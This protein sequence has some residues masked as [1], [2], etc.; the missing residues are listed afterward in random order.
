[1]LPDLL[2]AARAVHEMTGQ[3]VCRIESAQPAPFAF[4]HRGGVNAVCVSDAE[5]DVIVIEDGRRFNAYAE[6]IKQ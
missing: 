3:F 6:E 5:R 1:M 4:E 2:H